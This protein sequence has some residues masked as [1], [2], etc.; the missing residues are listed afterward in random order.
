MTAAPA[1]TAPVAVIPLPRRPGMPCIV[2]GH[3][4][5][6][7]IESDLAGPSSI[8]GIARRWDLHPE[9]VRRHL[10]AHLSPAIRQALYDSGRLS[11]LSIAERLAGL[12]ETAEDLRLD[13][14]ER[15]D[16]EFALRAGHEATSTLVALANRLGIQTGQAVDLIEEARGIAGAFGRVLRDH[17]E[18][19]PVLADALHEEGLVSFAY[20]IRNR[21]REEDE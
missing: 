18:F 17:P 11:V 1:T 19:A 20:S 7:A 9:A 5:R 13:A 15:G 12:A 14:E 10:R 21:T 2:C 4:D 6:H 3:A 16:H 8:R